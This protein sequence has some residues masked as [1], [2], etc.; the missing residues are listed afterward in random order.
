MVQQSTM[1]VISGDAISAGSSFS[2]VARIGME[3]PMSFAIMM[4][5]IKARP[6]TRAMTRLMT[7]SVLPIALM[8]A[9]PPSGYRGESSRWDACEYMEPA[10][11]LTRGEDV[12]V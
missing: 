7:E 5:A 9:A 1:V 8:E 11:Q 4:A 6:V 12:R 10:R 2:F 3:Q